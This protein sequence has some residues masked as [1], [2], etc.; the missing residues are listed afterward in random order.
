MHA[1]DVFNRYSRQIF[2][3]EIGVVGQRKIGEAKVLV[4]GA[5]G[6]GSPVIQYLAAAGVGGLAVVDFDE[7]EMHNLNRQVI[8][9]ESAI[10]KSKVDSASDFVRN[11]NSHISFVP[12]HLKVTIENARDLIRDYDMVVDGSDNFTTRYIVNDACV[13]LNKPLVYGSIF[14]FEGQV[15]VFNYNRSKNLR[16]LFPEAPNPE[17]VPN[18]DRNGVLGPLPGIVGTMMAMMVLKIIVG[19]PMATDQLTVIDTL[20]WRFM[21]VKF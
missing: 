18:C 4:I 15:A 17:D 3:E 1:D 11:F 6:L 5:G 13:A 2:I 10:G 7:V 20:N 12:L 19:L 21:T 14:A 8:H 9:L 16:D